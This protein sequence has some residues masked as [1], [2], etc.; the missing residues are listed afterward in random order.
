VRLA[1]AVDLPAQ[2]LVVGPPVR[3][4]ALPHLFGRRL[5][6][7]EIDR[8]AVEL[9]HRAQPGGVLPRIQRGVVLAAVE[10]DHVARMR[11]HQHRGAEFAREPVQARD[12]PVGIGHAPRARGQPRRQGIGNGGAVMRRAD[13]QRH[14]AAVKRED[15][16]PLILTAQRSRTISSALVGWMA[17]VAWKSASVAPIFTATAKPCRI[18]SAA[19]PTRCR[20]TT[21]FSSPTQMALNMLCCCTSARACSIGRKVVPWQLT[22]SAPKRSRASASVS[23]TLPSGGCENTTVGTLS[24]STRAPA[25][26][27]NTRSISLRASA[28]ATGVSA[29]RPV[30][31][32]TAYTPSALVAW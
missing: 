32:P 1:Q 20:P 15:I 8:A 11:R 5:P 29:R 3:L 28:I 12:V 23:P 7:F 27:P 24:W 26:P 30:T 16:H 22:A 6:A 9:A 17:M 21:R 19:S 4:H 31:S 25:S 10:V 2:R 13:K 14:A 18:S